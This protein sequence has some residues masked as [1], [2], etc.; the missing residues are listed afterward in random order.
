MFESSFL[1]PEYL[2][3]QMLL[4]CPSDPELNPAYNFRLT[5]DATIDGRFYKAGSIHPDCFSPLSYVYTGWALTNDSEALAFHVAYTW[6]DTVLP[7]S[8][9]ATNGWRDRDLN[10]A[11]FGFAGSGNAGGAIINQL[12]LMNI[13]RFLTTD[14]NTIFTSNELN[15]TLLPVMWDQISTNTTDFSHLPASGNVL[16]ITGSVSLK[17]YDKSSV[18][19]PISPM[20]AALNSGLTRASVD[21]CP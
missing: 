3:E 8:N 5:R 2:S 17:R 7:I 4:M 14:L 16:Y 9:S 1:Y 21:Y 19:F 10:V 12:S 11:S 6:L 20:Y 18:E 13:E 15:S